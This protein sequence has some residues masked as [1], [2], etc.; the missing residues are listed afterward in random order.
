MNKRK[1]ILKTFLAI[2]TIAFIAVI[3]LV[4]Y[5]MFKPET[6]KGSKKIVVEV[7]IPDKENQEFTINTDAEYLRQALD[8]INLIKGTEGDYGL[9]ISEVNGRVVDSSKQEWWCLTKNGEEVFT[10][11]DQTP[12]T[13]GDHYEFT[14]TVGY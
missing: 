6:T 13:D 9:F 1:E 4:A 11:V 14:L 10:G 2:G 12:I 5:Q 7:I 3:M 8:E